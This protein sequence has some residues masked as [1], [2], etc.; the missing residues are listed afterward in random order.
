[1]PVLP[2]P[3]TRTFMGTVRSHLD[4][5]ILVSAVNMSVSGF[6][7]KGAI[8]AIADRPG[9]EQLANNIF[10][11]SPERCDIVD[12]LRKT[13]NVGGR[14]KQDV[15][16]FIHSGKGVQRRSKNSKYFRGAHP[17]PDHASMDTWSITGCVAIA[18]VV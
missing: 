13:E 11:E 5:S 17:I 14:G 9:V 1:M 8:V 12:C 3:R 16:R 4:L 10:V 7:M 2:K 15:N 18:H 6:G